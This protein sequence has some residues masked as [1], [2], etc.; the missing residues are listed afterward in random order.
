M[1]KGFRKATTARL[2]IKRS[3][4]SFSQQASQKTDL[5]LTQKQDS[6]PSDIQTQVEKKKDDRGL[7]SIDEAIGSS[8]Q[9][10][11]DKF[12]VPDPLK[13]VSEFGPD[14][15]PYSTFPEEAKSLLHQ[16]FSLTIEEKRADFIARIEEAKTKVRAT[17]ISEE[18]KNKYLVHFDDI[19]D[20]KDIILL[21]N[22]CTDLIDKLGINL[23][24]LRK[25]QDKHYEI[26]IEYEMTRDLFEKQRVKDAF[27]EAHQEDNKIL[28]SYYKNHYFKAKMNNFKYFLFSNPYLPQDLRFHFYTSIFA[29]TVTAGFLAM[30]NPF[31]PLILTYDLY[32]LLGYSKV[33]NQ[34]VFLIALDETKRN[35]MLNRF[36]FLGYK[37][38]FK[39]NRIDMKRVRYMGEYENKFVTLDSKGILPS[40]N[41]LMGY[42]NIQKTE[43]NKQE[44]INSKIG[45][46]FSQTTSDQSQNQT[47]ETQVVDADLQNSKQK[48]N[49]RKFWKFMADNETFL[50]PIDH[51]KFEYSCLSKNLVFDVINGR[52]S[53]IL[54]HDFSTFEAI[55]KHLYD[56]YEQD[57]KN[58][59]NDMG[60]HYETE[61]DKLQRKYSYMRPNREFTGERENLKLQKVDDGTFIDNGYR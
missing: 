58:Y 32:L 21:D 49:F 11:L 54:N 15:D 39:A 47:Q 51:D 16:N 44:D 10:L 5:D 56:Q 1:L 24:I 37:T 29:T 34:T 38:E 41:R 40:L 50:I 59:M 7:I 31:L 26:D 57:Y 27:L 9:E 2:Y 14:K 45:K 22:E 6:Q 18:L 52:Q 20:R 3:I 23:E 55:Q 61:R 30:I 36:N 25:F 60:Q 46:D 13:R 53:Q 35:I 4:K 28:N 19:K 48:N 12:Q 42:G 43:Q 8:R 17:N 33:L